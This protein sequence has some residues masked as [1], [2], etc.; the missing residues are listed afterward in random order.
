MIFTEYSKV[1][2]LILAY[3]ER[4]YNE[5]ERLTPFFDTLIDLI[6]NNIQ[7]W[8]ITN[9]NATKLKLEN[10][11][12]YKKINVIGIKGWDDIWLRDLIGINTKD[13]VVKPYYHPQYC[14]L[15]KYKDYYENINKQ[16]RIIIKECLQKKI[17]YMPLVFDGGNFSNNSRTVF[18]TDKVLDDNRELS[19]SE[20]INIIQDFTQLRPEI[21]ERSK[22]DTIGHTD[23][24]LNFLSNDRVLLSN[25]PSLPF[26]KQDIEFIYKVRQ[27]LEEEKLE[28]IEMYDRPVDEIVPCECY[29]KTKMACFYSAR[30]DY[31]NFLRLNN[32][33]ILPE[34]SLPTLKETKYY[35][36]VNKEILIQQGFEVK[37]INCDMLSKEGGS[38][39]C[40]SY[41][42]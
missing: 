32:T 21:I 28:V 2:N 41:T 27:K 15:H 39:H 17:N 10:R 37:T 12:R 11:Y 19:K 8:L 35:N 3:P 1:S 34:Y 23:G 25:Y 4:Y 33:I 40:L 24:F 38:L 18:L 14:T 9:N 22:T 29:R 13:A 36:E 26:L 30:G 5:Y 31:I 7:L 16:S 6:P 20:V 42:F